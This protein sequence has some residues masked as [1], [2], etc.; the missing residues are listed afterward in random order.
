MSALP[1]EHED[2]WQK[3]ENNKNCSRSFKRNKYDTVRYDSSIIY[4][5]RVKTLFFFHLSRVF[6]S[7]HTS[8]F[9]TQ[10]RTVSVEIL[11]SWEIFLVYQKRHTA[12][13]CDVLILLSYDQL[14]EFSVCLYIYILCKVWFFLFLMLTLTYKFLIPTLCFMELHTSRG[15]SWRSWSR[16]II[17]KKKQ[18]KLSEM[19]WVT[20]LRLEISNYFL[21]IWEN[22]ERF[23]INA[24]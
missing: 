13:F 11:L 16:E 10:R 20:N 12:H 23:Q 2:C 3:K 5:R 1:K 6:S 24:K 7:S 14:L 9:K 17:W 4:M 22:S 21:Q 15:G 18:V 8:T 19:L